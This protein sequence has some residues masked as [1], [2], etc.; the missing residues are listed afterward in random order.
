M[1][2]QLDNIKQAWVDHNDVEEFGENY[3]VEVNN[4]E[5]ELWETLRESSKKMNTSRK[6]EALDKVMTREINGAGG[7]QMPTERG[8]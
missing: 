8:S 7:N 5:D 1:L 3:L 6:C 4:A 2:D